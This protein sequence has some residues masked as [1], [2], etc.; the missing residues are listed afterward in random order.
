GTLDNGLENIA[1]YLDLEPKKSV[2]LHSTVVND[3]VIG[4][5]L[6]YKP[7]FAHSQI[8][9]ILPRETSY[10]KGVCL[11]VNKNLREYLSEVGIAPKDN[12]YYIDKY[13]SKEKYPYFSVSG[14]FKEHLNYLTNKELKSLKNSTIVS[15]FISK[16]DELTANSLDGNL[17][18]DLKKQMKFNSKYYLRKLSESY[19]FSMPLGV[20]FKGL[21]SLECSFERLKSILTRS[22]C[23]VENSKIWCKFQS[24]TSGN[25]SYCFTGLSSESFQS[26]RNHIIEFCKKINI[27]EEDIENKV[28]LIL[29]IDVNSM[30]DEI[31]IANIGVEA[32][33]SGSSITLVGCVSQR[34]KNGKYIGSILD[35]ETKDYAVFAEEAAVPFLK[36]IQKEGYRGFMTIDV[37]LTKSM[38]S[39]IIK[40]YNIDP[41]ARFTAGTPLLS[42][43]QYSEKMSERE[44]FGFSYSN[45]VKDSI[46]LF[47]RVKYYC[48]DDL[49]LGEKSDYMGIIPLILNDVNY[50]EDNKRYLR[51]VVI[52]ESISKA[53]TIYSN[54][55]KKIL[56]D[57]E[58]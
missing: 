9:S 38:K 19:Q 12:Y 30:A 49:Y 21:S 31:Q 8:L 24:Q 32:V 11:Y 54:F 51:T 13:P 4:R 33:V 17:I 47:D 37:L 57:L 46:D 42:L 40:G 53:E 1:R 14:Y 27:K 48:G 22:S 39:G 36:A 26:T 5:K 56:K 3:D 15:S 34:S 43:L 28:P 52:S 44:L 35:R 58:I 7:S 10:P 45:A 50:F 25:G 2:F 41:N 16:D 6:F 55:K 18:M 29:E 20:G 23:Q